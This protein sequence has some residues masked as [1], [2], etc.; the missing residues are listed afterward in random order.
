M[1]PIHFLLVIVAVIVF[2][3][4]A[5]ADEAQPA[6]PETRPP[7]RDIQPLFQ[8]YCIRCHAGDK[9]KGELSLKR[10]AVRQ[11]AANRKLWSK[12]IHQ[13]KSAE[14]PTEEPLPSPLERQQLIGWFEHQLASIDW[15]RH[16]PATNQTGIQQH[17]C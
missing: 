12:A 2:D 13:L 8:K 9:P 1:N 6:E 17:H 3:G 5:V 10:I 4:R 15:A 11:T 7:V 14:M 16:D